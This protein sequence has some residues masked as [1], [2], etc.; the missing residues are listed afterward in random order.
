[1]NYPKILGTAS[2]IQHLHWLLLF[3][4]SYKC[5]V[6]AV[7]HVANC[8]SCQKAIA[9]KKRFSGFHLLM[10]IRDALDDLVPFV[11]FKKREK[12]PWGSVN[13]VF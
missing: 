3:C 7:Q 6:F 11:Q 9:R 12:H 1:M 4:A 5:T 10:S 13:H 2:F 8:M